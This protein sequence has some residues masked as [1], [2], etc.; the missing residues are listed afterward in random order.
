VVEDL[1]DVEE[2]EV[3]GAVFV[4]GAVEDARGGSAEVVGAEVSEVRGVGA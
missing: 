3:V 2:V 4:G 1:L